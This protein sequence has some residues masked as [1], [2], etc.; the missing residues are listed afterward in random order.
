M[1]VRT[2]TYI[3][4]VWFELYRILKYESELQHLFEI[5]PNY[6]HDVIPRR[7]RVFGYLPT[8]VGET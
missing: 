5:L 2:F 1:K 3:L 7:Y 8:A 6:L 4:I